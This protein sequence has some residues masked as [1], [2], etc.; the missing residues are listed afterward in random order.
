LQILCTKAL[1]QI[2]NYGFDKLKIHKICGDSGSDNPA[3]GR[4]MEKAGFTREGVFREHVYKDGQYVDVLH[5]GLI[6]PSD[7]RRFAG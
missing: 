6:N 2:V 1:R 3:S 5:W 4:V 7:K